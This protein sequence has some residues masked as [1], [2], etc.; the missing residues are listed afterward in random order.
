MAI[1]IQTAVNALW[2]A[3]FE[4]PYPGE[5]LQSLRFAALLGG[6][7]LLAV[8]FVSVWEILR[9]KENHATAKV[10]LRPRERGT[11]ELL[12][13]LREFMSRWEQ[14]ERL[15]DRQK[16]LMGVQGDIQRFAKEASDRLVV[17]GSKYADSWNGRLR[18]QVQIV[19]S[20]MQE[21]GLQA[22]SPLG[23]GVLLTDMEKKGKETYERA[24]ALVSFLAADATR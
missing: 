12:H 13:V 2:F 11:E 18:N 20:N 24:R 16:W 19:S 7:V 15:D 23:V 9:R 21:L 8:A 6:L 10:E 14:Y 17:L 4:E 3:I 5:T 1:A 22:V